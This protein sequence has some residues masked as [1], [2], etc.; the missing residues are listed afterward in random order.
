V[1][2][3]KRKDPFEEALS[4]GNS[5]AWES[6]WTGAAKAYKQAA[7]QRPEDPRAHMNLGL[8]YLNLGQLQN[9]LAEYQRTDQLEAGD[10]VAKTKVAELHEQLG[11]HEAAAQTYLTLAKL[12]EAE[13]S[14][15]QAIS[16][17]QAAVRLSP[18]LY[19]AH[20]N[21]SA[22]ALQMGHTD[23]AVESLLSM[24][25]IHQQN[26]ELGQAIAVC[27]QAREIAP[28]NAHV[29][30]VEERLR[31]G[32]GLNDEPDDKS[33]SE[34]DDQEETEHTL[35][36]EATDRAVTRLAERV[37]QEAEPTTP[38]T[39]SKTEIGALIAKALSC[40]KQGLAEEAIRYYE[41]I[42]N[43]GQQAPEVLFNLG[44]L[45]QETLRLD[46]AI[47]YLSRTRDTPDFAMASHLSLGQC[48]QL[49]GKFDQ[50][51]EHFLE[52]VKIVDLRT[53]GR[54]QADDLIQLYGQL[55]DSYEAKGDSEKAMAF[56]GALSTFLQGKGWEDKALEARHRMQILSSQGETISLAEILEKPGTD[57]VLSALATSKELAAQKRYSAATDVCFWALGKAPDYLPLHQQLA[58]ILAS[59]DR[60][61]EAT[62]K[63]RMIA[64]VYA[65]RGQQGKA[66]STCE[67]VLE[68]APMST[69][70]QTRLIELLIGQGELDKALEHYLSLADTHYRLA[71]M[72]EAIKQ[73][74]KALL[75]APR[76][77]PDRQ[78]EIHIQRRLADIYMQRLDWEK[79]V[80]SY[81]YI[82][83]H[84]P[85]DHEILI[86]L[87][88]LYRK[89]GNKSKA[90]GIV[91]ALVQLYER[92][93]NT[94]AIIE[95]IEEEAELTP[96]D[97]GLRIYLGEICSKAGRKRLA[98]D[99]WSEALQLQLA[100]GQR[101]QASATIRRIIALNPPN[102]S[103][104]KKLLATL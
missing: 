24:A 86:Q 74:K 15:Q 94:H 79:A 99:A 35:V 7:E 59:T 16:A 22:A 41:A 62:E 43:A 31:R 33:E 66:I 56:A 19:E 9:A 71:E 26:Q 2:R 6:D 45:Y 36:Q 14:V 100:K 47:A 60:V 52:A 25:K 4:A 37:F 85:D 57:E 96:D 98:M 30:Q 32:G 63:Y 23:L 29:Q 91:K 28:H 20:K 88:E 64:E 72:D 73:Y 83:A 44:R 8:A 12:Y 11:Q 17:W 80:E 84:Q 102:V 92:Q 21:L 54:D 69:N 77:S 90:R 40:Q 18:N 46:E 10:P 51:L 34:P 49:Q 65:V 97:I 50:A 67:R 48:Y 5:C 68:I 103:A 38:D 104:Y 95:V 55:A 42:I 81:E 70:V 27:R 87:L 78:W 82:L 75:L 53:V 101:S 76:G 13:G 1:W 58:D 39:A 3:S 93:E 61:Q 89:L